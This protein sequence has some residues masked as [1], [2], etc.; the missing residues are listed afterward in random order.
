MSDEWPSGNAADDSATRGWLVGH[1]IDPSEGVQ[2]KPRVSQHLLHRVGD[3][4]HELKNV[5]PLN[6]GAGGAP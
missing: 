3:A 1:F 4:G 6:D 5:F 2:L